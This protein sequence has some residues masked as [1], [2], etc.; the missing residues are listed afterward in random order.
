MKHSN[1]KRRD[2]FKMFDDAIASDWNAVDTIPLS[3]EGEF[4]VMTLSGLVRR[5]KSRGF[6]RNIRKADSYG[7]MRITV[8]SVTTGNY[9]AAIAWKWPDDKT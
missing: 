4:M 3:G 6:F 5:A 1:P 2:P 9:L 7:P 8:N